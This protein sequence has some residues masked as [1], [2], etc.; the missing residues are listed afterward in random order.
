MHITD[1]SKRKRNIMRKLTTL[2][3]TFTLVLLPSVLLAHGGGTHVRGT[4]TAADSTHIEVKTEDGHTV[5]IPV[6]ASTKYFRGKEAA[7]AADAVV[8]SR[9]VVHRD[10]DGNATEVHLPA[11]KPA[12]K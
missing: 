7:T 9:A 11:Q 12:A 10:K 8:G 4:V 3:A 2:A 5:S 1:A 6:N